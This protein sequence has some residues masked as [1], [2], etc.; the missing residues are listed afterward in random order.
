MCNVER[1]YDRTAI[2][3]HCR[4]CTYHITHPISSTVNTF[5]YNLPTV[6]WTMTCACFRHLLCLWSVL[7]VCLFS[8][9][10]NFLVTLHLDSKLY[11][12]QSGAVVFPL[13]NMSHSCTVHAS[14]LSNNSVINRSFSIS[15]QTLSCEEKTRSERGSPLKYRTS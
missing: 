10:L 15:D 9:K 12:L 11:L 5:F 6:L 3:L 14:T 13:C 1:N 4:K 7:G 2:R 8:D